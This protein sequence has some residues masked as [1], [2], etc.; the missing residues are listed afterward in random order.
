MVAETIDEVAELDL[1]NDDPTLP[2]GVYDEDGVR[3]EIPP[4]GR[5]SLPAP[6]AREFL[7]KHPRWVHLYE[8]KPIP[9]VEGE[10][11]VYI[12]N[13]TGSRMLPQDVEEVKNVDGRDVVKVIPNPNRT[14]Q[15]LKFELHGAQRI[16]GPDSS[17]KTKKDPNFTAELE[18]LRRYAL[19]EN[20]ANTILQ[21][22]ARV[23]KPYMAGRVV[24][25]PEPAEYEP[26]E[27][28][29]LDDIRLYAYLTDPTHFTEKRITHE[30]PPLSTFRD[31]DGK[32]NKSEV[33]ASK[34][35][36]L[37]DLF[38]ALIDDRYTKPTR[39]GFE[40]AKRDLEGV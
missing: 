39:A 8:E 30:Y 9:R 14:K 13:V 28:W 35:R 10:R 38:P 12:A 22:C 2:K 3:H 21:R 23:P 19:P 11:N 37:E 33:T 20:Y 25:V 29:N 24:R 34:R 36:L 31:S 32:L 27:T 7:A 1:K 17:R 6:L 15:V 26:N 16:V 40:K 4:L 18:P 5:V